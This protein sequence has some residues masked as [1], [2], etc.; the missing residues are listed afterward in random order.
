MLGDADSARIRF[1]E[2]TNWAKIGF[3]QSSLF[4]QRSPLVFSVVLG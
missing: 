2:I 3:C 4:V 1:K